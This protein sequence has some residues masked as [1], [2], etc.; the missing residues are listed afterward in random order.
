M[1]GVYGDDGGEVLKIFADFHHGG[2]AR[3]QVLLFQHRLH[4]G[5]NFP[6]ED[7]V[8]QTQQWCRP[9]DWLVCDDNWPIKLGGFPPLYKGA[10]FGV[11]Y[12]EF[13]DTQWDVIFLSR[14]E[15]QNVF[16]ELL[17]RHPHGKDTKVIGMTGN[18]CTV[19]DWDF[20]KNF[21][22]TDYLSY[23]TAPPHI[24]KIHYSQ[25]LGTQ[26][27]R[28]YIPV[29]EASLHTVN[30][31]VMCWPNFNQPW[32]WPREYSG[33][34]GRCP[35]CDGAAAG[36]TPAV[37]PYGI[38]K[39]AESLLPGHKFCDYGIAC[40]YPTVDE[41][42]LPDVYASGALTVHMKTYDGY[43]YSMLQSIRCG[44][45]VIVPRRFHRYRTANQFL[46]PGLTCFEVEWDGTDLARTIAYVTEDVVRCQN[47]SWDCYKAA[48]V[49]LGDRWW[50]HEAWRVKE[51][52]EVLI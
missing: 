26:Y 52:L 11:S 39:T 37:S 34:G 6:N 50:A 33:W 7:M 14:L 18:D 30:C 15:S 23:V 28:N 16:K 9:G 20:V 46:I 27:G 25:E 35:H 40:K 32:V 24:N 13:M 36:D 21:M 29:T 5:I 31:F 22:S 38:W 42:K 1:G 45:P 8:L 17:K 12:M 47:Y 44:R 43:G 49:L 51:F 19:Y 2:A 3:G 4:H 41:P 48:E 10:R